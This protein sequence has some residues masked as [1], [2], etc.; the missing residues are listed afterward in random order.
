M[1]K[2][3][4]SIKLLALSFFIIFLGYNCVQQYLTVFFYEKG[5]SFVGFYSLIIIYVLMLLSS[6]VAGMFVSKYGPKRA[7]S[8][9]SLFYGLFILSLLSGSLILIYL[10]SA[11]LGIAAAF[12][13]NGQNIYLIKSSTENVTGKG[14]GLFI[15]ALSLSTVLGNLMIWYLQHYFQLGT[16]FLIFSVLPFIGFF[17]L[18]A[19]PPVPTQYLPNKFQLM[20]KSLTSPTALRLS[21]LWFGFSFVSGLVICFLPIDINSLFGIKLVGR[22]QVS[23]MLCPFSYLT[24]LEKS[25]IFLEENL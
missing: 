1:T 5:I 6:P 12:L 25:L 14:A 23:F 17:F 4:F 11:L 22:F 3:N 13:W 10:S 8:I 7:M 9:A 2:I 18:L 15:F 24:F 19:L 20:K 21:L 16:I